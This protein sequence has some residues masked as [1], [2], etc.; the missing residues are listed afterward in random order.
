LLVLLI[1]LAFHL[2]P[3]LWHLCHVR[4]GCAMCVA[5]GLSSHH[6]RFQ[7]PAVYVRRQRNQFMYR[8]FRPEFLNLYASLPSGGLLSSDAYSAFGMHNF[9]VRSL[10]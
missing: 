10:C 3:R 7:G 1:E 2:S 9:R 6:V 4:G 5:A 8:R